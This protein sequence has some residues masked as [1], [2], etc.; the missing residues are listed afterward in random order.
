M[1]YILRFSDNSTPSLPATN[2]EE[3]QSLFAARLDVFD[4]ILGKT[5]NADFMR[6]HEELTRILLPL[7]CE[8][9]KGNYNLLGLVMDEEDYKHHYRTKFPTPTKPA[10]YDKAI[11]NNTT[12][13]AWS[14]A[15][16]IHTAKIVDYQLF[17]A[18]KHETC[19]F[20]LTVVYNK[21]VCRLRELI[22]FYT[23]VAPLY[24]L[25]HLQ[26]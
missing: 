6:L 11:L 14:K 3:I 4:P 25:D 19:N 2:P 23:A 1:R 21:W 22:T 18:V 20:I 16:A 12:N 8:V 17:A 13:V 24:L 26:K 9:E 15:K 5:I 10:V 7:P